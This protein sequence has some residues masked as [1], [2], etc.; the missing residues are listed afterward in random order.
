MPKSS[1]R[2]MKSRLAQVGYIKSFIICFF[3]SFLYFTC[4]FY[5]NSQ[6]L[7]SLE[8]KFSLVALSEIY[9]TCAKQNVFRE[10]NDDLWLSN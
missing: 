3:L 5:F 8:T 4:I 9:P 1:K 10:V 2:S 6:C 7:A